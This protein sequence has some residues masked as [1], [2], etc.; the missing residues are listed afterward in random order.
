MAKTDFTKVEQILAEGLRQ[1]QRDELLKL[2]D[3]AM[4]Q[5]PK[6]SATVNKKALILN[7]LIQWL[8]KLDSTI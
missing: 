7:Y 1:M 4:G 5:E 3:R 2:A 6:L 8:E